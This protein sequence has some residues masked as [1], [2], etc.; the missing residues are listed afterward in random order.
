MAQRWIKLNLDSP[1]GAQ[2]L[3]QDRILHKAIATE[4]DSR[5]VC[6]L[7]GLGIQQASRYTDAIAES[8]RLRP[9]ETEPARQDST[10][11]SHP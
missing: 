3:R 4:G 6:D 11:M 10:V 9:G 1:F 7:F 5:R 2:A 8:A